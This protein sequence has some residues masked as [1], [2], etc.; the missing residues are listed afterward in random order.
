[1]ALAIGFKHLINPLR[2]QRLLQRHARHHTHRRM[3]L[4]PLQYLCPD[5]PHLSLN[6]E[7]WRLRHSREDLE[8]DAL[9][10]P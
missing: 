6:L 9:Q 8:R 4:K 1:L 7:G 2:G 3:P 5:T 10:D